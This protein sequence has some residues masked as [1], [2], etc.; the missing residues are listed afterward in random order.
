LLGCDSEPIDG[1]KTIKPIDTIID[2]PVQENFQEYLYH[3]VDIDS[4][5]RNHYWSKV[6]GRK[7]LLEIIHTSSTPGLHDSG[8]QANWLILI[9][10]ISSFSFGDKVVFPSKTVHGYVNTTCPPF[11][12]YPLRVVS[13]EIDFMK[14]DS[15]E[16]N[17]FPTPVL[18]C[19]T[20][21]DT[22][23]PLSLYGR[24]YSCKLKN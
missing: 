22:P 10:D 12:A 15:D 5:K 4:T 8:C 24:I 13:G 6:E 23:L 16:V 7:T 18:K 20:G 9:D 21:D 19:L 11:A 17:F 1:A 3:N 14:I 2:N